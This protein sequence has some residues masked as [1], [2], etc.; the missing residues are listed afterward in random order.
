MIALLLACTGPGPDKPEL[1]PFPSAHLVAD[2]HLAIPGEEL[3]IAEGGT[4][5]DLERLGF[6]TG[7]SVVQTIVIDPGT[8]L[9]PDSLPTREDAGTRGSVQMWDL[10][11]GEPVLCSVYFLVPRD[12]VPAFRAAL[13]P[14]SDG[15]PSRMT[16]SG[17]WPPFNFVD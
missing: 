1:W 7:F 10:D 16:L 11:S 5:F 2:G 8:A 17:P 12:Q 9:D 4:R 15:D 3:P 13:S 6:R 14:M